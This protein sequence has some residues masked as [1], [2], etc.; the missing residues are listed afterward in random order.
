M[1]I[2]CTYCGKGADKP[3]GQVNR[4]RAN[5]H[6]IYCSYE[7][8]AA[9]RRKDTKPPGWHETRFQPSPGKVEI[10][11]P[12]CGVSF[13]LPPSKLSNNRRCSTECNAHYK[14]RHRERL[15]RKCRK[16]GKDFYP[17]PAQ[18]AAN[19]GHH[20]SR[21]CTRRDGKRAKWR[22]PKSVIMQIGT[23]Q[24]WRC[25]ICKCAIARKKYDIDH[26]VPLVKGGPHQSKNV[27]LLCP[28]CNRRKGAKDPIEYMQSLGRLL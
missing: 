23:A 9:G 28:T 8:S 6:N 7:C 10:R 17:R 24:R 13:W 21:E 12:E 22:L 16:C 3:S 26:I 14:A 11:C 25:A 19:R 2:V 20:C 15:R 27:Q 4:T 5:G 18:L 1:L